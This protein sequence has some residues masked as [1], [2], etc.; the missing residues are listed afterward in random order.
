MPDN[1]PRTT[2]F[3]DRLRFHA[4][5][6]P[7]APAILSPGQPPLTF[8]GLLVQAKA[9]AGRLEALGLTRDGVVA[10]VL[11][12]AAQTLCAF[13]GSIGVTGFAPLN[14]EL[15][16]AEYEE[17]LKDLRPTALLVPA[18]EPSFARRAAESAGIPIFEARPAAEAGAGLFTLSGRE[19][20]PA[21][22][23]D[24]GA[25]RAAALLMQTSATTGRAKFVPLTHGNLTAIADAAIRAL[26]L[27]STDCFL[28]MMPLYHLQGLL[29]AAPQL[30]EG[31]SVVFATPF[32]AERFPG[33]MEEFRPTWYTGGPALHG[34][35]LALF[36]ENPDILRG[37]A[38]TPGAIDRF[39][40]AGGVAGRTGGD[41]AV[42]RC[43]RLWVD[44]SRR[45][46]QHADGA[47][48]EQGGIGGDAAYSG[49]RNHG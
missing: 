5:R 42:A 39:S 19:V 18:D 33:W 15:R 44:R 10:S 30:I 21:A 35:I 4:N 24:A 23:T 14:P 7:D 28:S 48:P 11:P 12:E 22:A 36:R 16:E 3:I 49:G 37:S 26:M 47:V 46:H 25:S 31:G 8:A 34:T 13:F 45:G 17:A 27:G 32:N 38:A 29:S 1:T 20:A 2:D 40:L 43:G 6:T 41:T 9:L